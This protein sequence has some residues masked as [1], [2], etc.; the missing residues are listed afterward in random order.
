M[1]YLKRDGRGQ[2][3]LKA[4]SDGRVMITQERINPDLTI[5]EMLVYEGMDEVY[6]LTFNVIPLDMSKNFRLINEI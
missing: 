4:M 3:L 2:L 1:V 6:K 5:P